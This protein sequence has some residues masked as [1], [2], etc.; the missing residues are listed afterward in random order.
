MIA[1]RL[2]LCPV[3]TSEFSTR[4]L[5][6]AVALGRWYGAEVTV[7]FV[8]P[9]GLPPALWFGATTALPLA[10]P[11]EREMTAVA[12]RDYVRDATGA[13]PAVLVSEG[14]VVAEI[15][16]VAGELPADLIVMGTHGRGAVFDLVVGSVSTAVLRGSR[17]PVLFVPVGKSATQDA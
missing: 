1:F 9:L 14:P 4:A 3:D 7:L 6:H 2:V 8:R 17:I 5:E 11:H 15:L 12:I 16:R 13:E 10:E